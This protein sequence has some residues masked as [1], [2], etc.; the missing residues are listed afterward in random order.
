MGS[1][2][3]KSSKPWK[4]VHFD[5]RFNEV[6]ETWPAKDYLRGSD[7]GDDVIEQALSEWELEEDEERLRQLE[8]RWAYFE[9]NLPAGESCEERR[10]FQLTSGQQNVSF[11]QHHLPQTKT[12]EMSEKA[13]E[14]LLEQRF[15]EFQDNL[16]HSDTQSQTRHQSQPPDLVEEV[17]ILKAKLAA[18]EAR[19]KELEAKLRQVQ[20]AWMPAKGA[21]YLPGARTRISPTIL[22]KNSVTSRSS[23][24]P[25]K[26]VFEGDQSLSPTSPNLDE[27]WQSCLVPTN[28]PMREAI[29]REH[30][31]NKERLRR[32]E[33]VM[34]KVQE[35]IRARQ[36]K[37][38]E[39]KELEKQ[40]TS[41]KRPPRRHLQDKKNFVL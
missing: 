31:K 26:S 39:K 19:N 33:E 41:Y 28:V 1:R 29:A 3:Y 30:Q 17:R 7:P 15:H 27:S 21:G 32:E 20:V 6:G 9:R 4:R 10:L 2:K 18:A 8:D 16:N 37:E 11:L 12:N 25:T 38:S 14:S 24:K 35:K 23:T 34:R 13:L 40:K 5:L 22:K 36:K